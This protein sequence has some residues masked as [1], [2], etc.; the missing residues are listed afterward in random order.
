MLRRVKASRTAKTGRN[1]KK[2]EKKC[3]LK[4][5]RNPRKRNLGKRK[6][7]ELLL[8][9]NNNPNN[10][11]AQLKVVTSIRYDSVMNKRQ[12]T[13]E[14]DAMTSTST[15]FTTKSRGKTKELDDHKT[16]K[17]LKGGNDNIPIFK[18]PFR[19]EKTGRCKYFKVF[20]EKD[21]RWLDGI[22]HILIDN[23]GDDD[24]ETDQE[25]NLEPPATIEEILQPIQ[26]RSSSKTGS[27]LSF[28]ESLTWAFK[29]L[30][31]FVNNF[32]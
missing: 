24:C 6:R 25:T 32:K 19:V 5:S 12:K 9:E 1:N 18:K 21:L 26:Q 16:Y 3:K 27:S 28:K 13:E 11:W 2:L 14:D 23:G 17:R 7:K 30:W 22:S 31:S 20:N 4:A 8:S 10:D 29:S 15:A